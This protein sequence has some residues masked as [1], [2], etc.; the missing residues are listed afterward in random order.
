MPIATWPIQ[1]VL[2]ILVQ[3]RMSALEA[4]GVGH[5]VLQRT[6][7]GPAVFNE[8]LNYYREIM[9]SET[10]R[11][12]LEVAGMSETGKFGRFHQFLYKENGELAVF[13]RATFGWMDLRA[14]K[15][16]DP[17]EELLRAFHRMPKAPGFVVLTSA[18]TRVGM[19][20]PESY[21]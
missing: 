8:Q 12:V 17:P 14:R 19:E 16:T 20:V 10:V 2:S 3:T 21:G 11:S 1:Q 4:A 5:A 18:D 6:Q 15:L 9:P 13:C 7:T